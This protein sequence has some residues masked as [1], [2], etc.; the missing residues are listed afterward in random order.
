MSR[1]QADKTDW[2]HIV[3]DHQ[4]RVLP[5][6]R[7]QIPDFAASESLEKQMEAR[8]QLRRLIEQGRWWYGLMTP[9][10]SWISVWYSC[11][12]RILIFAMLFMGY[13]LNAYMYVQ[14]L[15]YRADTVSADSSF[16]DS[17]MTFWLWYGTVNLES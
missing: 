16:G 4:K 14:V 2:N 8:R 11:P 6:K 3:P 9:I 7:S 10:R 17:G 15:Q 1:D 12:G 13:M 5:W